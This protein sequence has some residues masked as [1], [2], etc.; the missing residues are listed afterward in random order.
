VWHRRHHRLK[1]VCWHAIWYPPKVT[2]QLSTIRLCLGG[3]VHH[4]CTGK[5]GHCQTWERM[6]CLRW[7]TA[8][9]DAVTGTAFFLTFFS[10]FLT[11]TVLQAS[12]CNPPDVWMQLRQSGNSQRSRSGLVAAGS[13]VSWVWGC[14]VFAVIAFLVRMAYGV[15]Q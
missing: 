3:R 4:A 2:L 11:A 12:W 14:V 6:R 8:F 15:A 7:C 10:L 5:L 1:R 9:H 13:P